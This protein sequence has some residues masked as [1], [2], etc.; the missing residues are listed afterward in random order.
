MI[1]AKLRKLIK[2]PKLGR[3]ITVRL[4]NKVEEELGVGVL[5]MRILVLEELRAND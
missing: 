4:W 1:K 2:S 3:I 5:P